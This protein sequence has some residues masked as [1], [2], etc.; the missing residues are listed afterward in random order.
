M[1]DGCKKEKQEAEA[2]SFQ[3]FDR[4]TRLEIKEDLSTL[5]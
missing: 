4:I 5:T 2:I 1:R 3:L